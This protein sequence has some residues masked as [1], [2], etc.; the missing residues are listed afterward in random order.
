M[1]ALF[2]EGSDFLAKPYDIDQLSAKVA[3]MV[4]GS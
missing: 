3:E 2:V 1:K 4:S